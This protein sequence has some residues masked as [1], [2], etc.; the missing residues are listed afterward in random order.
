MSF[1]LTFF[2]SRRIPEMGF[3]KITKYLYNIE[4]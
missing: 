2:Y 4:I 3:L 1:I